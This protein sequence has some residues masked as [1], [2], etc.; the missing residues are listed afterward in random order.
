MSKVR[1][2]IKGWLRVLLIIIP[3]VVFVGVSQFLAMKVLGHKP[4][5]G[6]FTPTTYQLTVLE[7]FML[8]AT[9][10]IVAI[11]RRW[12]DR[13]SFVALVLD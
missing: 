10:A 3:F 8:A 12:V 1:K 13:E 7:L 9:F 6:Q 4:T 11:F 5:G 2:P